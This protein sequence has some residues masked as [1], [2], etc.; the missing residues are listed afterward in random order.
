MLHSGPSS[1]VLR[2]T[3]ACLAL[4]FAAF[5]SACE[6]KSPASL[7]PQASAL[8]SAAPATQMSR[9]FVVTTDESNVDFTMDAE[10][11]KISG[12][13]PKSIQG[14]LFVDLKRIGKTS[15]LLKVDLLDLTL[16]QRKRKKAGEEFGEEVKQEKQNED[17]RI[18]LQINDDAP[19][20]AREQNRW[21]EFK[22]EEVT[23][24]ST[25]DVSAMSGAERQ[26]TATVEGTVRLHGRV[27][28]KTAKLMLTFHFDGDEPKS[29]SV[30]TLEPIDI[31][32]EEY[33]IHPRKA[34]DKLADATLETLGAKVAKIA[35][36]N[37][38]FEAS[39]K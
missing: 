26:V 36:I 25:S 2:R 20:D 19:A 5:G 30:K 12:R 14:E 1:I 33:D 38:Q 31:S 4:A 11:E 34:F 35:K 21:V 24:A 22:L 17:A 6:E 18:W 29:L 15:G 10:L 37:V 7:A 32:L 27:T 28:K 8:A 39:A 3:A 16:F 9:K 23:E 13:A